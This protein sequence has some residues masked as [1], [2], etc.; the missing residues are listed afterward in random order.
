MPIILTTNISAKQTKIKLKKFC[1]D[2]CCSS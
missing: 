1:G 2:T